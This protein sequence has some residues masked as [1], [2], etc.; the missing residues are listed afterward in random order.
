MLRHGAHRGSHVGR[1]VD[2]AKLVRDGEASAAAPPIRLSA[3]DSDFINGW[4][5]GERRVQV[6]LARRPLPA[7]CEGASGGY[8]VL[9]QVLARLY[10]H[11]SGNED[12]SSRLS[13]SSY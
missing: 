6:L 3:K 4:V 2:D 7:T 8:Y 5:G 1:G 12:C 9:Y 11:P 13:V 10:L